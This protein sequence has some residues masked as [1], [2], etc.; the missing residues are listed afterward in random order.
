MARMREMTQS[1]DFPN[2]KPVILDEVGT[3]DEGGSKAAWITSGYNEVFRRWPTVKAIVY[4]DVNMT[5]RNKSH[6]DWRLRFPEDGSALDAIRS[7]AE[8][9]RF[10]GHIE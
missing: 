5:A 4:F 9:P 7:L 1:A 2:G 10:Q 3:V 8:Q 6:P